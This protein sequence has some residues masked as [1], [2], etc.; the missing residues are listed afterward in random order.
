MHRVKAETGM[1]FLAREEQCAAWYKLSSVQVNDWL[2][3]VTRR[4]G[5]NN[6]N[7][8]GAGKSEESVSSDIYTTSYQL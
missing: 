2:N 1:F 6:M 5:L 8:R 7:H 3:D 4:S